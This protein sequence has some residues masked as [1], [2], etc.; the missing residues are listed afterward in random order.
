MPASKTV[1]GV[2]RTAEKVT[3][4]SFRVG[5][6][7]LPGPSIGK[8]CDFPGVRPVAHFCHTPGAPCHDLEEVLLRISTKLT[9]GFSATTLVLFGGYALWH[10]QAETREL[11]GA[12]EKETRL[13]TRSSPPS[14]LVRSA[15]KSSSF[16]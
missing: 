2:A 7:G 12:L 3:R 9:L 13:L 1:P 5:P 8:P 15:I 4:R 6:A 14:C 11:Y 16:W 10:V